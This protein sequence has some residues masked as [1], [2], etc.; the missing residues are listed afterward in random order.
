MII[1]STQTGSSKIVLIRFGAA[2]VAHKF[3]F[4]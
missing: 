4:G 1:S 2:A 3:G